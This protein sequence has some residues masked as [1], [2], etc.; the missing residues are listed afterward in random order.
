[1]GMCIG[2][3]CCQALKGTRRSREGERLILVLVERGCTGA[4]A[5][6]SP[7]SN[8]LVPEVIA[9]K[10]NVSHVRVLCVRLCAK[11]HQDWRN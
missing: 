6:L 4:L 9:G 5:F 1:M 3:G 8:Q 10:V 2:S 11:S 7:G